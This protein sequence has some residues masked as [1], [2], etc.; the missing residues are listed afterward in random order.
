MPQNSTIANAVPA[1]D[2]QNNF[3][4]RLRE[5]VAAVV[6]IFRVAVCAAAPLIVT[7]AGLRLQVAES[8]AAVGETEQL[9][10][11]APVRPPAGVTVIIEVF[12]V[13][14][15]GLTVMAPLFESAKPGGIGAVT[16]AATVVVWVTEPA[17]PVI[18][19]V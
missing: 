3:S 12:P 5:A 8:L 11:T 16:V 15:P 10:L 19:I 4:E 1:A 7:E 18:V 9:R 6:V 13:V 17:I 2:G 14:A